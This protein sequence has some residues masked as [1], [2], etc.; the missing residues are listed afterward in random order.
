[1]EAWKTAQLWIRDASA[2][3]VVAG[4]GMSAGLSLQDDEGWEA[5]VAIV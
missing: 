2:V 5:A 1:M 3:L 4:A